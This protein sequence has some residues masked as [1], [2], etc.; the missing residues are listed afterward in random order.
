MLNQDVLERD[1]QTR[2]KNFIELFQKGVERAVSQVQAF[3][4]KES[5]LQHDINLSAELRDK[6]IRQLKNSGGMRDQAIQALA[7]THD[8]ALDTLIVLANDHE[9]I[10]AKAINAWDLGKLN[11][12]KVYYQGRFKELRNHGDYDPGATLAK[13]AKAS[14]EPH[15]MRAVAEVLN[16]SGDLALSKKANELKEAAVKLLPDADTNQAD[17]ALGDAMFKYDRMRTALS[18]AFK[19]VNFSPP[20]PGDPLGRSL[21]RRKLERTK[22]GG[23]AAIVYTDKEGNEAARIEYNKE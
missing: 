17:Q 9:K 4:A 1:Y 20:S 11:E 2:T 7:N 16:G 10:Q 6:M 3:H 5:D 15:K 22:D 23:L 12:A 13:E 8:Q 19:S 14:N 18:D 21:A